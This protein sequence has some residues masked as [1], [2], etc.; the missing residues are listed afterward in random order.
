MEPLDGKGVLGRFGG[1]FVMQIILKGCGIIAGQLKE[2]VLN[3]RIFRNGVPPLVQSVM[4]VYSVELIEEGF[5]FI[6]I[7]V[8]EI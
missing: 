8:G 5:Q 3:K 6:V 4:I 1:S 7:V 2:Y